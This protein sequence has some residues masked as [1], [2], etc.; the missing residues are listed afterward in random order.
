MAD[1]SV[2]R[3]G[4]GKKSVTGRRGITGIQFSGKL[5]ERVPATQPT[6][7]AQATSGQTTRRGPG[8][9][10]A[11]GQ[12][13]LGVNYLGRLHQVATALEAGAKKMTSATKNVVPAAQVINNVVRER[14]SP[15]PS[16]TTSAPARMEVNRTTGKTTGFTSGTTTG[17]TMT[18]AGTAYKTAESAYQRQQRMAAEKSGGS[19][20]STGGGSSRS[21]GGS[22]G[23]RGGTGPGGMGYSGRGTGGK[24]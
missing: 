11:G 6:R 1:Q 9:S 3:S 7:T 21:T 14:T 17:K 5:Q 8:Y 12:G 24:H 10:I 4:G 16:R 22:T 2:T 19:M 18:K 20:R 15:T 13:V 23:G